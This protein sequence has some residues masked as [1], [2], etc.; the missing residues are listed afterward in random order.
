MPHLVDQRRSDPIPDHSF[1]R[2]ANDRDRVLPSSRQ[3]GVCPT[4]RAA[5]PAV[6]VAD[7][8]RWP[9]VV[10][11][12]VQGVGRGDIQP[13]QP[14]TDPMLTAL[15]HDIGEQIELGQCQVEPQ[16]DEGE[17]PLLF[18]RRYRRTASTE[19]AHVPDDLSLQLHPAVDEVA[20]DA[21]LRG[22]RQRGRGHHGLLQRKG[23]HPSQ[24]GEQGPS[25][26]LEQPLGKHGIG[27]RQSP[28]SDSADDDVPAAADPAAGVLP[29]PTT[30]GRD[31]RLA[32]TH[33]DWPGRDRSAAVDGIT[34]GG[35]VAAGEIAAVVTGVPNA[36]YPP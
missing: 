9:E 33:I 34:I 17:S 11:S 27:H 10:R 15:G 31:V 28:P 26:P 16:P 3:S 12:D 1:P 25:F 36:R 22:R 20:L 4:D 14:H 2:D 5:Q 35:R 24:S 29:A 23:P 21:D 32:A 6:Q 19:P 13:G 30:D 8:G 7:H 18:L